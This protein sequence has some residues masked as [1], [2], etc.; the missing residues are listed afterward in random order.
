MIIYLLLYSLILFLNPLLNKY[1]NGKKIYCC[2]I[3]LVLILIAGLRNENMG[4]VD[5]VLV[6][7]PNYFD[8]LENDFWYIFTLKDYG[9]QVL[10]FILTRI[11]QS[12]FQLYIFVFSIPYIVAVTY[13][14]YK[15]SNKPHLS[16]II[17]TCLYFF[18]ISFTLIR[19][20]N[21]MAFLLL[22]L[23]F[24]LNNKN[25]KFIFFVLLASLFHQ[26]CFLFIIIWPLSKITIKKEILYLAIICTIVF[27][28]FPQQILDFVFRNIIQSDRFGRYETK[29]HQKNLVFFLINLF[30]WIVE[31]INIKDIK[32]D[33]KLTILF[34]NSTISLIISPLTPVLGEASR[35]C[36]LFMISNI[37]LL[38][39]S[40]NRFRYE[41]ERKFISFV[42]SVV[43][44]AYFLFFLGPDTNSVPF[45]FFDI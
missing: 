14:I 21:G 9:F 41:N 26:I 11:F 18:E 36:Y 29:A 44:I 37:I 32:K 25:K 42:S 4:M 3:C 16:F 15:Y 12:N 20:V 39:E 35:I 43:L 27:L 8:V 1:K 13:F 31:L 45:N 22:A 34:V 5:T 23:H 24:L 19:Q 30:I 33:R 38:P 40:I 17:F 2:F 6:Y 28:I 10:T 7:K